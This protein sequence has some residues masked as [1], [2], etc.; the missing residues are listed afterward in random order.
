M[1]LRCL[2]G[3]DSSNG[4]HGNGLSFGICDACGRMLVRRLAGRWYAVP[5]GYALEWDDEGQHAVSPNELLRIARRRAPLQRF[6]RRPY[7]FGGYYSD[8]A[9][10]TGPG[11]WIS[12]KRK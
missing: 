1:K 8:D 3:H 5:R 7:S 4:R 6:R 11:P 2:F 12:K 9:I 10:E